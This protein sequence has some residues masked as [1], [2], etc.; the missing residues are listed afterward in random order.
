MMLRLR[1]LFL[2]ELLSYF[3]QIPSLDIVI[4]FEEDLSEFIVAS[5]IVFVVEVVEPIK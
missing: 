3:S 5:Q 1:F 4:C 2:H